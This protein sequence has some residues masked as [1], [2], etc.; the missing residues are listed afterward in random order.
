[1]NGVSLM[2]SIAMIIMSIFYIYLFYADVWIWKNFKKSNRNLENSKTFHNRTYTVV[3][4]LFTD[5]LNM[6][7][8]KSSG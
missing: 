8:Q 5:V 2:I 1:M 3:Q 6:N 4:H 7:K